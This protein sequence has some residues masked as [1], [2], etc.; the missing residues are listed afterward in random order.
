MYIYIY[1]YISLSLYIYVYIDIDIWFSGEICGSRRE[2]TVNLR[3]DSSDRSLQTSPTTSGVARTCNP[4][5]GRPLRQKAHL[6]RTNKTS[7]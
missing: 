6:R 7:N 1:I 4:F 2:R 3:L 5:A